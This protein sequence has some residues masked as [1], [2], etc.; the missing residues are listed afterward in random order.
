DARLQPLLPETILTMVLRQ[1]GSASLHNET[2][3]DTLVSG[4]QQQ[5]RMV[6]HSPGSSL[7]IV[8]FTEVGA[9]AFLHQPADQLYNRT[10]PL[11]AILPQQEIERIQNT[12]ADSREITQQVIEIERFL[13]AR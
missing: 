2:L 12:L 3:P 11:E 5:T 13:T 4:L 6:A 8:R 10:S 7:V 9:P 1:S